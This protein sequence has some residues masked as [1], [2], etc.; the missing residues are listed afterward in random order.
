MLGKADSSLAPDNFLAD[1]KSRHL[2][3]ILSKGGVH[4]LAAQYQGQVAN[5]PKNRSFA[6]SA[7]LGVMSSQSYSQPVG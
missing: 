3:A 5:I 7:I 2:E 1:H 4:P 6:V